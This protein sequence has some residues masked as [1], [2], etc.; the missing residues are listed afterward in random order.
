MFSSSEPEHVQ[1]RG[2]VPHFYGVRTPREED[3]EM[4]YSIVLGKGLGLHLGTK[5][6][7]VENLTSGMTRPCVMDIKAGRLNSPPGATKKKIA[8]KAESCAGTKDHT[9]LVSRE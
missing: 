2:L 3:G 6:V 9:A 4:A 1:W 8:A 5:Y 7:F